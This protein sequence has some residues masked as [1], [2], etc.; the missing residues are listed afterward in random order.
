VIDIQTEEV[1]P[2][3]EATQWVP[4][5]LGKKRPAVSTLWR[6]YKLGI[7]GVRLETILV[8]T[9]RCTSRQ[10]LQRFFSAVTAANEGSSRPAGDRAEAKRLEDSREAEREFKA[11]PARRR[12]RKVVAVEGAH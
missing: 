1:A 11:V 6:W 5:R 9:V 12:R 4:R 8:G 3:A 2:F 10:S 7:N